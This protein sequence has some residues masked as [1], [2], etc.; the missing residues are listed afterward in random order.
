M[1]PQA[2]PVNKYV[3]QSPVTELQLMLSAT[4]PIP[5]TLLPVAQRV[6][7]SN[8]IGIGAPVQSLTPMYAFPVKD[9]REAVGLGVGVTGGVGA[10]I[11]G[12]EVT[13]ANGLEVGG[14][15]AMVGKSDGANV[16]E[17]VGGVGMFVGANVGESDGTEVGE[18]VGGEGMFVGV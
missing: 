17:S 2:T 7:G 14:F 1:V 5:D 18:S 12:D 9:G 15:P 10:K 3:V 8:V 6:C 11:T 16:G 4:G 13:G